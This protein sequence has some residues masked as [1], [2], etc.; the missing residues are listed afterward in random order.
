MAELN[1]ERNQREKSAL[2]PSVTINECYEFI[3][4]IDTLGGK[5]VSYSSI[6]DLMGLTSQ[7]TK[8]FNYRISS[9]KQFGLI[10]TG[11]STAQL[12]DAAKKILYPVNEEDKRNLLIEA[13]QTPPLYRKLIERF[14]DK[15]LPPNTILGNILLN[16]YRI[17]K[18]VKDA[19]ADCFIKS[20]E[21]LQ[22]LIN[23][24][25]CLNRGDSSMPDDEYAQTSQMDTQLSLNNSQQGRSH[26]SES[27]KIPAFDKGFNFD[28]P[29]LS[30]KTASV[31][32]PDGVS[33]KDLDYI[34]LF[35]SNMLPKFI[36]N[37]KEEIQTKE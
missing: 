17:I 28:I 27:L 25:L 30:G 2:Y 33:E 36:E 5:S 9:A 24:V 19:A 35:I 13:F 7:A 18:S 21:Q 31:F 22:L 8:S 23:G 1:T 32:I 3:R 37:L 34:A 29:T 10:T 20:S 15:T 4:Q 14:K 11:N 6:L 16:D 12:T 26:S